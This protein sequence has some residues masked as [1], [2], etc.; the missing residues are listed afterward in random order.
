MLKVPLK[1]YMPN[2]GSM[3]TVRGAYGPLKTINRAQKPNRVSCNR[4]SK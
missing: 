3:N 4:S 1:K 2:E